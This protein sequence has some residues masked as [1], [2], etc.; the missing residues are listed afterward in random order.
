LDVAIEAAL[1]P[2][3]P[4]PDFIRGLVREYGKELDADLISV[5]RVAKL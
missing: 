3:T 1:A 2:A 4:M 5:R